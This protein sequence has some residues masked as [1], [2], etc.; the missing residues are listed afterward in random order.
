MSDLG[1][2]LSQFP[3]QPRDP[4]LG[5]SCPPAALP[6]VFLDGKTQPEDL[7]KRRGQAAA[8]GVTT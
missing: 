3:G 7:L 1:T 2:I 6:S 8:K 5:T 4:Q